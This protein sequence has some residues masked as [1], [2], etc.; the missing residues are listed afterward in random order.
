MTRE[1]W[2]ELVGIAGQA[3]YVATLYARTAAVWWPTTVALAATG[4][5]TGGQS[6][7]GALN[8]KLWEEWR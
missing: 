2:L 8:T 4:R 1:K 6:V 7:G 3:T 5:I